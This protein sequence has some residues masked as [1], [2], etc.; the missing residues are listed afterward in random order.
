MDDKLHQALVDMAMSFYVGE[1]CRIC[2]ETIT[3]DDLQ[4]LVYA[5]YAKDNKARSAHGKCWN[6]NKDNKAQWVYSED[7]VSSNG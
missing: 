5:G 4:E 3:K 2:G 6:D 7:E 1:P